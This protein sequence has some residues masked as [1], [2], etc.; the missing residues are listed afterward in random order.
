LIGDAATL[1]RTHG[2]TLAHLPATVHAFILVELQKWPTLFQPEQRYQ[3]ALLEHLSRLPKSSLDSATRGIARIE[4][5]PA[6][7]RSPIAIP[8]V[9]GCRAGAAAPAR[10]AGRLAQRGRRVFRTI[11]PALEAQLY[12]ADAPRRL[13]VQ[14]YGSGIAVQR[15]KLWSRFKGA[16]VRV[17]LD[18]ARRRHRTS[19]PAIAWRAGWRRLP[20]LLTRPP[21]RLRS[22][23][24]SSN[25]TKRCTPSATSGRRSAGARADRL[26]YDRLRRIAT[27]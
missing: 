1:A 13:V 20:A 24:G 4:G 23:R 21:R 27:I 25:R 17:P 14:I 9:P 16:G 8:P 18:L 2:E 6:S 26:S 7:T 12:P 15:D 22:T 19:S 3:R 10:A 11:D 5:Q